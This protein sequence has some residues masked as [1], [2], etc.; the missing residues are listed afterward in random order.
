MLPLPVPPMLETALD[1]PGQARLVAFS[2]SPCGDEAMYQDGQ[3]SGVCDWLA[4]LSFVRHPTVEPL[5][6]PFDLGSSEEEA[7]HW[8]LLDREA[9]TL[10]VVP[11]Q[12]AAARLSQQWHTR[13]AVP[14]RLAAPDPVP[15][16]LAALTGKRGWVVVWVNGAPVRQQAQQQVQAAQVEALCCW[17]NHQQEGGSTV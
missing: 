15:E 4:Y 10:S 13:P 1:Y 11:A 9:R 6:R 5:L 12:Q 2:W 3:R 14:L 8:L 17:L 7:R 16:V